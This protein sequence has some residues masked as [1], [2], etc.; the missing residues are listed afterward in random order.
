M[1]MILI[2]TDDLLQ[3]SFSLQ[4]ILGVSINFSTSVAHQSTL[5]TSVVFHCV[6]LIPVTHHSRLS[7]SVA[8]HCAPQNYVAHCCTSSTSVVHHYILSNYMVHYCMLQIYRSLYR[9]EALLPW[10]QCH[11]RCY[12]VYH[13]QHQI[14]EPLPCSTLCTVSWPKQYGHL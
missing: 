8:L 1:I 13:A 4:P 12:G 3:C 5:T 6:C 14:A 10:L 9:L 11:G 7:N 2:E